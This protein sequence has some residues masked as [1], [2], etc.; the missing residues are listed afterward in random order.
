MMNETNWMDRGILTDLAARIVL[1][2]MTAIY[3]ANRVFVQ[4]RHRN[5]LAVM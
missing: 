2:E 5:N 4:R 3:S 1:Q